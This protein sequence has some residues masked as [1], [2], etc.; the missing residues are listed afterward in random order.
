VDSL[1]FL[2]SLERLGMKFGL[3]NMVKICAALQNPERAFRSVIIAGTNGKG[4]V[5][6]MLSASLYAAG[7]RTGRYTSP[8][9]ERLEERF[10]IGEEEVDS[11]ALESAADAVRT[12][13]ERL[14]RE[15]ALEGLPTFFECVTATAFELFRRM[16]VEVAVVEVGLGGRLDATNVIT[17]MAA[18]ITSIDFDHQDLLGGTLASIAREK[19]GVIKRGMPVVAGWLP[20]EAMEV[21]EEVC[22]AE[23]ARVVRVPDRVRV[24]A[25]VTAERTVATLQTD[26]TSLR[27]VPL[28]L[29]GRHQ[30]HNAAVALCLME[31]LADA[32]LDLPASAIRSGLTDARWPGRLERL[33]WRGAEVVLDAAHNPAG[34]RALASYLREAGWIGVTLVIGAMAD[35]DVSG[36]VSEL[37]PCAASIVCTTPPNA[38]AMPAETLAAAAAR[39]SPASTRII[40]IPDPAEAIAHACR[41]GARVVAAGSIFLIGPLRGILR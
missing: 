27:D 35:K 3:E 8:H 12:A 25:D 2:F 38:R 30:A 29:T 20:Q 14:V 37:A 34:A 28:A 18:A 4:S 31:T 36:I 17:P 41:D 33:R 32:G 21:I 16:S 19:A 9:L 40:S 11:A 6:A 24:S 1:Q 22:R 15:G 7:Y 13:V 5:A 39:V 10:V 26:R 23:Q